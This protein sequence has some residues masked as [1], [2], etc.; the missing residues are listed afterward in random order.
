MERGDEMDR[1]RRDWLGER[2]DEEGGRFRGRGWRVEGAVGGRSGRGSTSTLVKRKDK[3][4][5]KDQILGKV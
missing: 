4:K 3:N 1:W 2:E 5:Y